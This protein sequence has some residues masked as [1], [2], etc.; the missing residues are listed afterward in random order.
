[1]K[2]KFIKKSK[3]AIPETMDDGESNGWTG[4]VHNR[5]SG[6]VV[7]RNSK[8]R[9]LRGRRQKKR[10][11]MFNRM[12]VNNTLAL[13]TCRWSLNW[14]AHTQ[15]G[16]NAGFIMLG[17]GGT[18]TGYMHMPCHLY[19]LVTLNDGLSTPAMRQ[20]QP[21][22]L[23]YNPT[24]DIYAYG[25]GVPTLY[26]ASGLD[27]TDGVPTGSGVYGGTLSYVTSTQASSGGSMN[28]D[29]SAFYTG[30]HDISSMWSSD[31]L[32]Y[33]NVMNSRYHM[34]K[35]ID[36]TLQL[37]GSNIQS[38]HYRIDL[39]QFTEDDFCPTNPTKKTNSTLTNLGGVRNTTLASVND[40]DKFRSMWNSLI[41]PYTDNPM[42]KI[43]GD[44]SGIKI[45]RSWKINIPEQDTSA[46]DTVPCV[47]K[48]IRIPIGK[49]VTSSVRKSPAGV[50][51]EEVPYTAYNYASTYA[52]DNT[53][54]FDSNGRLKEN[55]RLYL[56]I[57]A[58]NTHQLT[59]S[60]VSDSHFHN[61]RQTFPATA[62]NTHYL[63][64]TYNID[65][66][67]KFVTVR[68]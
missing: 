47:Q 44:R 62:P 31:G 53:L 16:K 37:F 6:L 9:K 8:W 40:Y 25:P 29:S 68:N 27:G 26:T 42:I 20:S 30:G 33:S 43:A 4:N 39:V 5:G 13:S 24:T 64:P 41:I 14:Q 67:S 55:Q 10:E 51:P 60:V 28:A 50:G 49:M 12:V 36:C 38:V 56:M 59:S 34:L 15:L 45:L 3:S 66:R 23:L 58:T 61:V 1:M 22:S 48:K 57:R 65:L 2:K 63:P 18:G 54:S 52:G 21:L 46:W 11:R 19:E 35:E 17:N 32:P 7:L